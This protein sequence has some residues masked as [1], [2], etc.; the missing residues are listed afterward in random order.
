MKEH[1]ARFGITCKEPE[2]LEN[3]T[4]VVLGLQ[5][6]G[7]HGMLRWKRHSSNFQFHHMME[8]LLYR[9]LVRHFPVCGWLQLGMAFIKCIMNA[10]TSGQDYITDDPSCEDH[11]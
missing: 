11:V 4:Q 6:W 3:D 2:H 10:I 9:K 5:V 8:C 1:F 7:E